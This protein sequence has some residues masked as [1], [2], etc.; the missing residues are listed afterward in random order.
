MSKVEIVK[1]NK[2]KVLLPLW[3][4]KRNSRIV[5]PILA[6]Q[7]KPNYYKNSIK[8]DEKKVAHTIETVM[9]IIKEMNCS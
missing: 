6:F 2:I 8:E 7:E 3:F 9:M 1:V 4:L 5:V